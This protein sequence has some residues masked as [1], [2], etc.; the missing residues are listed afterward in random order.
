MTSWFAIPL[1]IIFALASLS[2]QSDKSSSKNDS[3][4]DKSEQ[5]DQNSSK[6]KS[7]QAGESSS[8]NSPSEVCENAGEASS[9]RT[10]NIVSIRMIGSVLPE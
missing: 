4:K 1:A 10:Q 5:T 3:E 2:V 6:D 8:E 9:P 7:E